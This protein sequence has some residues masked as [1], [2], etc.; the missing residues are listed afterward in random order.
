MGGGGGVYSTSSKFLSFQLTWKKFSLF[1]SLGLSWRMRQPFLYV[2]ILNNKLLYDF[3]TWVIETRKTFICHDFWDFFS[4]KCYTKFPASCHQE[5]ACLRAES[6]ATFAF[7]FQVAA[8]SHRKMTSPPSVSS[9]RPW[10]NKNN[11]PS[12]FSSVYEQGGATKPLEDLFCH[13]IMHILY[14]VLYTVCLQVPGCN[15]FQ[16]SMNL[17][18]YFHAI[19]NFNFE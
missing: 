12:S 6:F 5:I 7:N 14:N 16:M 3:C 2:L 17:K 15:N 11:F 4:L 19:L 18:H 1:R 9:W 10:K 13:N 8:T